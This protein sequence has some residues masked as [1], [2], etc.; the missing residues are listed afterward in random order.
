MA[1]KACKAGRIKINDLA[2]KPSYLIE[3]GEIVGVRKDSFNFSFKVLELID[4]R[5]SATLAAP[6][7]DNVTPE[8]E[9]N[10]YE[11]WYIGKASPERRERGSGRPT[12]KERRQI[13]DFKEDF[14]DVEDD[15]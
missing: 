6:C 10:K 7:Y 11:S 4:K 5:V 12:K 13:I 1:T 9:L 3:G 14:F 15:I 8:D 2:V